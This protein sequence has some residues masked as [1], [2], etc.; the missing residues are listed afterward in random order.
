MP[1]ESIE[2]CYTTVQKLTDM[3]EIKF[4]STNCKQL[5]GCDLGT[6]EGQNT[7]KSN[8]LIE[9]CRDY[10][11]EATRMVMLIIEETSQNIHGV[12]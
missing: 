3:F 11:Q 1:D 9:Q 5:I 4:G 10:T 12:Q 2:T 7:F 8:N 6:E